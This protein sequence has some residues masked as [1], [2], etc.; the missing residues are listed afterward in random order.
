MVLPVPEDEVKQP[1]RKFDVP[2]V[3]SFGRNRETWKYH[4]TEDGG[5]PEL[6]TL[7]I[8]KANQLQA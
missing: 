2:V 3:I 8:S 6:P 1:E 5:V 4:A 7:P